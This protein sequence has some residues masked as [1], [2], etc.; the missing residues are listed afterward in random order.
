MTQK[1]TLENIHKTILIK[2]DILLKITKKLELKKY[3]KIINNIYDLYLLTIID[4]L[5]QYYKNYHDKINIYKCTIKY[6][7]RLD[8][9]NILNKIEIIYN[10]LINI[11]TENNIKDDKIKV[12]LLSYNNYIIYYNE[13][14]KIN[15]EICLC[16]NVEKIYIN[17]KTIVCSKCGKFYSQEYGQLEKIYEDTQN[18]KY[19]FLRHYR[20]WLEKILATNNKYLTKYNKEI[21]ILENKINNDYPLEQQRNKLNIYN[22]RYYLKSTNLTKLNDLVPLLLKK[23]TK[24]EPPQ[25]TAKEYFEIENLFIQVM[26]VYDTIKQNNEINRK[27]YPY[28]IYKIIEYYFKNNKDKLKILNF[29]H[30]Q[31]KKH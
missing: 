3:Y 22:I 15:N 20:I 11:I 18:T 23:I 13:N 17:Q 24:N 29:I 25:L 8:N 9:I 6:K 16:K 2:I 19:D 27:Y 21:E 30:L 10:E 31:K 14:E 1:E 5:V 12:D 7:H 26:K 4:I 28:F